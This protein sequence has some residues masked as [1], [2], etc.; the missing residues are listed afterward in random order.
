MPNPSDQRPDP[1]ALLAQVQQAERLA[2][3]GNLRIFFGAAP[4]VGKSFAMLGAARELK[5]EGVDVVIGYVELHGRPETEAL[6]EGL[7]LL[8]PLRLEHRGI[9]LTEF[10]LDACLARAP[11]VVLVDELAHTN[12]SGARHAKRWMDVEELLDAG[13]DVYTTVNVQHIESLNDVVA[14]IT[15]V[16]V[17][18]TVPD[19]V[20]DGAD[21]VELIDLPP[22]ELLERL[23]EGKVYVDDKVRH[24]LSSFFRKGNLIALRQLALRAT[25]DRVDAAM[26]EYRQNH[27]IRETWAAGERILVCVGPD[28]LSERLVRAARRMSNA[29][30][31]EWMA[32]Y[33][34]TPH[35]VRLSREARDRVLQTLKLAESLGAQTENLSGE[36][37]AGELIDFARQHNISKIVVGKPSRSRWRDRL[38]PSL[39][40][41]IARNSGDID[42]Y[43]ISG[44]PGAQTVRPPRVPQ[45]S[46]KWPAYV[47]ATV[48]VALVTLFCGAVFNTIERTNLVMIY[49]LGIVFVAARFGR[50]P[51]ILASILSVSV[52]D[53]LYVPPRLS[54]AVSDAQYLIT[55]AVMICTGLIIS[56]LTARTKHQAHV[57]R[58][59]ERRSSELYA[60]SRE[61]S[62][63]RDME[64][65]AEILV[66]HVTSAIEGQAAVLLPD[67]EGHLL[68]PTHFCTRGTPAKSEMRYPVPGND[69]GIAQWGYDHRQK[70]GHGTDTLASADA[71][72]FPLNALRRCIGVLGLRPK[73]ARQLSIPEQMHLLESF[74]NQAAIAMERVQ[75]A[76]AAQTADTQIASEQLRSTLL[77][78][79]SHDFR[80]PLA[81]II[82]ATSTLL[83]DA[84]TNL[85]PSRRRELLRSTLDESQRLHR[86]VGNL[87]DLTR[88]TSGPIELKREWVAI[89][90]VIGAVLNRLRDTIGKREIRLQ[91]PDDLPLVRCDEVMIEQV[92][93]N[94]VENALKHTPPESP[95]RIT[96]K[97]WPAVMEVSVADSGAG[98]PAGEEQLVFD[99]FHRGRREAAQSGFGL[100]LTICRTIVDAH[101]GQISA[102]NL[103][104]GG[105]EF[106]FSL[107]LD[108]ATPTQ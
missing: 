67:A 100:G 20:F 65:L 82:G 69:L 51:S 9:A 60:L 58:Q 91:I 107:P 37:V 32:V 84:S 59:R 13:I 11:K 77:A 2:R 86:L 62:Q 88:L 83:D 49:L 54:F 36:S 25:A 48:V 16:Q 104:E 66:R 53:F 71:I 19:K 50:G 8:P 23:R 98:L 22:D 10:D 93:F 73:D 90:E 46:S 95:V 52:F 56:T 7:E 43:V 79:I 87:L 39:V 5:A 30:H 38:R 76:L 29:L 34:E 63:K 6:L 105:A 24:A 31:A 33:V 35:L 57:A 17:R 68:D 44:E 89:D 108:P 12:H 72:Y 40:D 92:V 41:E 81:S 28:P 106:R 70:S 42:V 99:K 80:T 15:G 102:R 64:E 78:S 94:L 103:P 47:K 74:V 3:R 27:A 26:R 4:G 55:F 96:V 1:D 101:G 45:R 97:A 85:E 75:L 21:E 14:Q 61:L 18:E